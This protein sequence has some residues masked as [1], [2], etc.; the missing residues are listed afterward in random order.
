[1]QQLTPGPKIRWSV[2]GNCPRDAEG[3]GRTFPD[4]GKKCSSRPSGTMAAVGRGGVSLKLI[5]VPDPRIPPRIPLR[6]PS[7]LR[8]TREVSHLL[9]KCKIQAALES[10]SL[11][12]LQL[13]EEEVVVVRREK[14]EVV[15]SLILEAVY[16]CKISNGR[17]PL[18]SVLG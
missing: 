14:T 18:T 9:R 2:T 12:F 7:S 1:M 6:R 17:S 10:H 13:V 15:D 4:V 3:A 16:L 5:L 8:G 11:A